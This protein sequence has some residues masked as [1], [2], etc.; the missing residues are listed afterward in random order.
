M[1]RCDLGSTRDV[2]TV[3]DVGKGERTAEES[4]DRPHRYQTLHIR[5]ERCGNLQ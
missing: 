3:N 1:S 2:C 4:A 5:A